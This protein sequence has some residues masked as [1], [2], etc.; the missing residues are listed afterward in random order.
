MQACSCA[1]QEGEPLVAIR[2]WFHC[3]RHELVQESC[4]TTMR[5]DWDVTSAAAPPVSAT[6]KIPSNISRRCIW[7][8]SLA[9]SPLG[10]R[11]SARR[12]VGSARF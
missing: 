11:G 7:H 5:E 4:A 10:S 2:H 9:G 12:I 3:A 6:A 8:L 1:S